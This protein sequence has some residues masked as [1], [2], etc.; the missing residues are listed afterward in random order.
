MCALILPSL[1]LQQKV[2]L[3]LICH[4]FKNVAPTITQ[5]AF[6]HLKQ[7][8][9]KKTAPLVSHPFT[10]FLFLLVAKLFARADVLSRAQIR[11]SSDPFYCSHSWRGQRW[12]T[13]SLFLGLGFC[14]SCNTAG[15]SSWSR[16]LAGCPAPAPGSPD[17]TS[18]FL[19]TS[20]V[21][22]RQGLSSQKPH[23]APGPTKRLQTVAPQPVIPGPA[24]SRSA[25]ASRCQWLLLQVRSMQSLLPH[26]T[27]PLTQQHLGQVLFRASRTP[28]APTLLQPPAR[29]THLSQHPETLA[30]CPLLSQALE[31][32][33][34]R[35]KSARGPSRPGVH[36]CCTIAARACLPHSGLSPGWPSSWRLSLPNVRE[37]ICSLSAAPL[38]GKVPGERGF[39]YFV[40][41][42]VSLLS[43]ASLVALRVKHLPAV[44]ENWVQFPGWEDPLEKERATHSFHL[45]GKFHGRRSLAGCSPWD[46]KGSHMTEQLHFYL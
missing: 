43:R 37:D 25:E 40:F 46:R 31:R 45:P 3:P 15:G 36:H 4:R 30:W 1:Q 16:F 23:P 20:R 34:D 19:P 38:R 32:P 7:T 18:C 14:L 44:R 42:F 22:G 2:C 6:I 8:T 10:P 29:A 27:S 35:D 26:L 28:A 11:F 17:L 5:C 13:R 33:T 12:R 21:Q 9:D 41:L 24:S 39:R